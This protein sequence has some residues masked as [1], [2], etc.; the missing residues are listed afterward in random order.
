MQ[1]VMPSEFKRAMV[2]LLDNAPQMIEDFHASGTAQTRHKLH[3]RLRNLKTG[4]LNDRTFTENERLPVVSLQHRKVQFSYKRGDSYVFLDTENFEEYELSAEQ[5]G[6]RHWFVKENEEGK[7]LLLDGRLLDVVLPGH[8]ALKV[9]DT[10]PAQSGGSDAA[11]KPAKLESGLDIMVPLF[12]G[13][14]DAIRV[15]TATRK[16]LGKENA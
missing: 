11:W 9:V 2:L 5:I 8:V 12:I 10:A 6:E 1:T 7:A 14:G 3:V 15:D 13:Q 4:R 16:Y